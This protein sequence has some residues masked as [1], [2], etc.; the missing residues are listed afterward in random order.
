MACCGLRVTGYVLRI[1]VG[2]V[3]DPPVVSAI[4]QE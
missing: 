4:E 1:T 2:T 3:A